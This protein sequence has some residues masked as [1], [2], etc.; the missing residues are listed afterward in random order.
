MNTGSH[1]L[2]VPPELAE[3]LIAGRQLPRM[4]SARAGILRTPRDAMV[5]CLQSYIAENRPATASVEQAPS[6]ARMVKFD[7]RDYAGWMSSFVTFFNGI[8]KHEF[9]VPETHAVQIPDIARIAVFGDW[10]TG[11]Y[12]APLIGAAIDRE[13]V[14][15]AIHLGDVYY[16]GTVKEQRERCL[17]LWPMKAK[18]GRACNGNHCMYSGGDGYFDETL[19]TLGQQASCFALANDYWLVLGLDTA[20]TDFAVDEV[21]MQWIEAMVAKYTGRALILMSHHQ[22]FS[23]Y[24]AHGDSPQFTSGFAT[25]ICRRVPVNSWYFGHEHQCILYNRDPITHVYG[26][27]VGNGGFPADRMPILDSWTG[28]GNDWYSFVERVRSGIIW[29]APNAQLGDDYAPQGFMTLTLSGDGIRE[30]VHDTIGGKVW[31]GLRQ[32]KEIT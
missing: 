16:S 18:I 24:D 21:Q 28:A 29:N 12:G 32:V 27:L 31:E 15:V 7:D 30:T 26:R 22:P 6:R 19:R 9:I 14:D 20:Y 5:A 1:D 4:I 23:V 13:G 25:E 8:K 10:G 2:I 17:S 11:L 3:A